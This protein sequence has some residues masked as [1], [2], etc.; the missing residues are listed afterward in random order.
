MLS[1]A[2]ASW[3]SPVTLHSREVT[4]HQRLAGAG[5]CFSASAPPF[6]CATAQS[7]LQRMTVRRT[8]WG[9]VQ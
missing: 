6:L 7:A 4:D 2:N 8:C 1:S 9:G 3:V 5:Y